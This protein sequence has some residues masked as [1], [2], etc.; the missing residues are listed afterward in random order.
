MKSLLDRL[1]TLATIVALF[2]LLAGY[3]YA[4]DKFPKKC[5]PFGTAAVHHTLD[6]ACGLAGQPDNDA[7]RLQNLAKTNFCATGTPQV[8]QLTDFVALQQAVERAGVQFGNPHRGEHGPPDDRAPLKALP[9]VSLKEGEVVSMVGFILDPHYSPK[10]A[11]QQGESVNCHRKG[12]PNAD[13]H[14]NL[15]EEPVEL[16]KK[17]KEGELCKTVSAEII[18]H[19]RPAFLEVDQLE[20]AQDFPVKVTGQLFFDGS[21]KPCSGSHAKSGDPARTSL[22]EIHPVY[23]IEV[24]SE[25]GIDACDPNDKSKWTTLEKWQEEDFE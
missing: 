24:C 25:R 22:W 17:N 18:P 7:G 1:A 5:I 12:H 3:A 19:Y 10:K 11:S 16:T 21:H 23:K 15:S 8:V 14:L 13:I 4:T 20:L 2:H 6:T 9:G